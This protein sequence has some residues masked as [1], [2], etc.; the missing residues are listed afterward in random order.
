MLLYLAVQAV[1]SNLITPL[2]QQHNVDLPPVL[3]VGIQIL[4]GV[5]FGIL[6]LIAAAPMAV[7]GMIL[8]KRLYVEDVLGDQVE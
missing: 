5:L 7:C 3:N 2:V 1:E 8:V 6:G 4:S